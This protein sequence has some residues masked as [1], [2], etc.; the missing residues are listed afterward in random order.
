MTVKRWSQNVVEMLVSGQ[1]A[2]LTEE[3]LNQNKTHEAVLRRLSKAQVW[4]L[5]SF[6]EG[7]TKWSSKADKGSDLS[8]RVEGEEKGGRIRYG[9]RQ[10]R[11][12]E[13]QENK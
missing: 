7:E 12:L 8:G 13:D 10:E 1:G 2:I 5:D 11:R 9:G 6:L 3:C 4:I